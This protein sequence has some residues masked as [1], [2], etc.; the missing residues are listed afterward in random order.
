MVLVLLA[1][2]QLLVGILRCVNGRWRVWGVDVQRLISSLLAAWHG[3]LARIDSNHVFVVLVSTVV[4]LPVITVLLIAATI[5]RSTYHANF[6]ASK[7]TILVL[8]R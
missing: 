3:W 5:G 7:S 2:V 4:F 6:Q 8:R 1:S